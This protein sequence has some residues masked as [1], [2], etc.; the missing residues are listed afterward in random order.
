[1]INK[2]INKKDLSDLELDSLPDGFAIV[3]EDDKPVG[4]IIKYEYYKYIQWLIGK[5]K[6]Y[7]SNKNESE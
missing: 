7:V 2:K 1:M 3:F 6:E 4:A 5:V